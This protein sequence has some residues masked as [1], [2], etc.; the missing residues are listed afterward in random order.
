MENIWFIYIN[1]EDLIFLQSCGEV[2]ESGFKSFYKKE[3]FFIKAP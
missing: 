2:A 1:A 3:R